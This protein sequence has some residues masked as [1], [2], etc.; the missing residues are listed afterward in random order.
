MKWNSEYD[1][2]RSTVEHFLL[3]LIHENQFACPINFHAFMA[4]HCTFAYNLSIYLFTQFVSM[5]TKKL[6]NFIRI[7]NYLVRLIRQ[8]Q[9]KWITIAEQSIQ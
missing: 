1:Y 4:L 6:L 2:R 8:S 3:N 7:G 9:L 5:A